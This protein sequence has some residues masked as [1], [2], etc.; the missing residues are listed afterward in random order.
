M[1]KED[2]TLHVGMSHKM[3]CQQLSVN[4]SQLYVWLKRDQLGFGLQTQ[5][6]R[7][8]ETVLHPAAKRV[9]K[10]GSKKCLQSTR[11]LARRITKTSYKTSPGYSVI[12][13]ESDAKTNRKTTNPLPEVRARA[14]ALVR[15]G[16]T[17]GGLVGQVAVQGVSPSGPPQP[18]TTVRGWPEARVKF[19]CERRDYFSLSPLHSGPAVAQNRDQLNQGRQRWIHV[20]TGVINSTETDFEHYFL[21]IACQKEWKLRAQAHSIWPIFRILNVVQ[22]YVHFLCIYGFQIIHKLL[23]SLSGI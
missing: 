16:L 17:E 5:P 11:K 22:P 20:L 2:R 6:A 19:C 10:M 4:R 3:V 8:R 12:H 14:R 18:T 9:I 15:R 1:Q 23:L 13:T 7:G 21:C